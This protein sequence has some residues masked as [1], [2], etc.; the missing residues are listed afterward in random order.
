MRRCVSVWLP[1]WPIE[2]RRRS[3][4]HGTHVGAG[5]YEPPFVLAA[6]GRH[7]LLV[8]AANEGAR[9]QGIHPGLALADARARFP[10]LLSAPSEMDADA[11]AL[12]R[13]AL[14]LGR[15]GPARHVEMAGDDGE[16]L[17]LE[18]AHGL[19]V[20]I[21]GAAHLFG[22]EAALL[23][24]LVSRLAAAGITARAGLADT[25]AA[26]FALARLAT[27]PA[28]PAAIARPGNLAAD[29]APLPI[30]GLRL[31]PATRLL[32]RRLGL[33]RIGQLYAIPRPALERRFREV[34]AKGRSEAA[35]RAAATAAAAVLLR[36]DQALGRI[37][38]PRRPLAEPPCHMARQALAEPLLTSA[39]LIHVT[40]ALCAEIAVSLETAGAGARRF[41]LTL[42][43]VD[44]TAAEIALGTSRAVRHPRHLLSLL[45]EKLAEV[46]AG[47]GI[48][49]VTLAAAEVER[50]EDVQDALG[51]QGA[52]DD[53]QRLSSLVDRLVTRLGRDRVLHLEARA[54]HIPELAEVPVPAMRG[55]H[56][57][58]GSK[59][60]PSR[61][62][63]PAP[64][65]CQAPSAAR[66]PFLLPAP[67]P[68]A[69]TAEV[70]EGAP[71]SF[72]WRRL[73][74][75]IRRAEGPERIAPEWWTDLGPRRTPLQQTEGAPGRPAAEE[76]EPFWDG[77]SRT[78]RRPDPRTRTR[79]YYRLE[80]ESGRRYWVFR[81]GLYS[82]ESDAQPCWYVHG[83][84]A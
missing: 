74:R 62:P 64:A 14:W 22:G 70:P 52:T 67:E 55:S 35:R 49:V 79:D 4:H 71:V 47:F 77:P 2:R 40:H 38:E 27:S 78:P 7:G 28:A 72:T 24:D 37:A 80:D 5:A 13:L 17:V 51:G 21:T 68:I 48:D 61:D 16:G 19:W 26:A 69:V 6:P 56:E 60:G 9:A 29:L 84:F 32:L 1:R 54:S 44:G 39:A 15:Y 11:A 43:R 20:D 3:Q 30:D 59:R 50:L 45:D 73:T 23:D 75:R 66:P 58:S 82:E 12:T 36:L 10:A 83:L 25:G 65:S 57:V 53:A 31:A 46:D 18:G 33:K 41:V 42:Y 76:E 8:T 63:P 81:A 34:S